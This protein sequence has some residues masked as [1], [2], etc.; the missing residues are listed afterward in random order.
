MVT[1]TPARPAIA[2]PMTNTEGDHPVGIDAKDRRHAP[3]LLGGAADAPQPG[4][5]NNPVRISIPTS[6]ATRINTL[7]Q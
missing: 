2:A 1:S 6:A 3:V 5:L 7:V 4:I